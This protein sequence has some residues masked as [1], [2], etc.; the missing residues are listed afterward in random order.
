VFS[1]EAESPDAQLS[2]AAANRYAEVYI[3][4]QAEDLISDYESRERIVRDR[5]ADVERLLDLGGGGDVESLE[6][7]RREYG[8]E[9]EDLRVS[10]E[11][12]RTSGSQIID[13]AGVA[14]SPYTP[15]PVRDG[16][17]ALVFG[18]LLGTGLAFVR[19]NLDTTLRSPDDLAGIVGKPTLAVVPM[20]AG[21]RDSGRPQ[22]V[23]QDQPRAPASEAYRSLRTTVQFLGLQEPLKTVAVTSPRPGDGKTT[24]AANLAVVSARAGQRVVLVDCDLRQPRVHEF[25]GLPNHDGFTSLLLGQATDDVAHQVEGEPNLLVVTAGPVPPDPSEL[26][27]SSQARDAIARIA[28]AADLVLIDTAPVLAVTD[29]LIVSGMVDGVILV[30]AAGSTDS[31]QVGRAVDQLS[32][33]DAPLLGAVLNRFQATAA[34]G[35]GTYDYGY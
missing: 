35:Y 3:D 12:A 9:L 4:N 2:A 32:Q 22:I 26:L 19:A 16:V 6:Q 30:A 34:A 11:L 23:A 15:T 13:Q 25:F 20:I 14:G 29:P 27:S 1:F 33:V 18:L 17:L 7:Q 31:R 28:S 5:L 8:Q 10:I 21:W 24:T